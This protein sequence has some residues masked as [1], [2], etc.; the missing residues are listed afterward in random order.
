MSSLKEMFSTPKRAALAVA[1]LCVILVTAGVCIVM[2]ANGARGPEQSTAIGGEAAQNFAF[3]DAG[4]DPASAQA[5]KV[6][7]ER[8]QGTFVYEV[9][10]LAGETEYEY[11]INAADG[12]VVKKEQ[13][14]VMGP[15]NSVPVAGTITLE[16]ARDIALADAGVAREEAVFT[17]AKQDMERGVPVFEFKFY[18]GNVE[19]EYEINGQTGAVYSKKTT[20]YVSQDPAGTPPPV[21]TA[22]PASQPPASQPPAT[23]PPATAKPTPAPATQPPATQAPRPTQPSNSFIGSDAAKQAALA[24]AGVSAGDARFTKVRMDYE[25]GVPVYEVEFY[26]ATHEYDYEIHA[27]NGSVF[28]KEVEAHQTS[29]NHHG[30]TGTQTGADIGA[31]AAK[32]AALNHAGCAAGDVVFTKVERDYDDGWLIYE[33]EFYKG[34]LEYEFEI[35]GTSG[36]VLKF[37]R[38]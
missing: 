4:V 13:K 7:Y 18:G 8:Y 12:S 20:T 19:Y 17:E 37:E 14:A 25:D 27:Q 11:K 33:I 15:G 35:D 22:P 34:G 26:T 24:D 5:V 16:E 30:G 29:G 32:N 2:I 28:H 9:E 3:A 1:C 21:Q 10:F 31:E 36:A 23:Q 6:K 38:D